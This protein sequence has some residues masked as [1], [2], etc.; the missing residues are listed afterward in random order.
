M[1]GQS[2]ILSSSAASREVALPDSD[3]HTQQSRFDHE[4]IDISQ[5]P[6]F[7]LSTQTTLTTDVSSGS[8]TLNQAALMSKLDL[9]K[10]NEKR[11]GST[12][13][14]NYDSSSEAQTATPQDHHLGKSRSV[15]WLSPTMMVVS[16]IAGV[17]IAIGHHLYYQWLNEQ[18]VGDSN[19][20]QWALRIGNGLSILVNVL[21]KAAV[22]IAYVQ[23]LWK[24]LSRNFLSFSTINDAFG[25]GQNLFSFLNWELLSKLRVILPIASLFP[26]ATLSVVRG[27]AVNVTEVEALNVALQNSEFVSFYDP[28]GKYSTAQNF[29]KMVSGIAVTGDLP[30]L[31][32]PENLE[33]GNVTYQLNNYLPLLRCNPASEAVKTTFTNLLVETRGNDGPFPEFNETNN[34][35][36]LLALDEHLDWSYFDASRGLNVT[37]GIGY[38]GVIP[39]NM[40]HDNSSSTAALWNTSQRSDIGSLDTLGQIWIAIANYDGGKKEVEFI[41]CELYNA[42]LGLNVTFVNDVSTVQIDRREWLEPINLASMNTLGAPPD[43]LSYSIF[44]VEVCSYLMGTFGWSKVAAN[45]GNM[46]VESTAD[47]VVHT[48]ELMSTNLIF[49]S[50]LNN[51]RSAIMEIIGE[52]WLEYVPYDIQN[53]SL[54]ALV[55]E[56]AL[57]STLGALSNWDFCE[58][59]NVTVSIA[60]AQNVYLYE[61]RS[62]I[63]SYALA[64][65]ASIAAVIV[66]L[67]ALHCNGVGY[68]S[69]VTTFAV[70]MQDSKVRDVL[71]QYPGGAQPVDRNL[72]KVKLRFEIG[73]GFVVDDSGSR[74]TV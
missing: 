68:D 50:Q 21:L 10:A 2:R 62:L 55:E 29:Q 28:F 37:G 53:I 4:S 71:R 32:I 47:F 61:S 51:M 48:N 69:T 16:L 54:S 46:S 60:T 58:Y 56:F 70:T 27:Q 17:I 44:F 66:G 20:Q 9:L 7:P 72:G 33:P 67:S 41:N 30:P 8:P 25:L 43:L 12:Q 22:G 73:N 63:I 52:E 38:F 31:V 65:V 42:S 19:R 36:S 49:H 18:R 15:H 23:Y 1:E 5:H 40:L 6:E 3:H 26:P 14:K 64:A 11:S 57:N 59:E 74:P 35:T 45:G 13:E 39:Y 24:T 34:A